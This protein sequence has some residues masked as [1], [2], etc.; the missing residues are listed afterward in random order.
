MAPPGASYPAKG[1]SVEGLYF[2][3]SEHRRGFQRFGRQK[4]RSQKEFDREEGLDPR[5]SPFGGETIYPAGDG[6]QEGVSSPPLEI[7]V[8][9]KALF[10]KDG[11]MKL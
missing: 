5:E 7:I 6:F 8:Q 2:E 1:G 4:G 9:I 11:F 3:E 10:E